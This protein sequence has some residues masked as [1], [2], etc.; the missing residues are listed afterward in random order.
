MQKPFQLKALSESRKLTQLF[1]TVMVALFSFLHQN[2]AYS[3]IENNIQSF[4]SNSNTKTN[5]GVTSESYIS[6]DPNSDVNRNQVVDLSFDGKWANEKA[7]T[8]VSARAALGVNKPSLYQIWSVPEVYRTYKLSN[9]NDFTFGRKLENWSVADQT[10]QLGI[11]QPRTRW[12]FLLPEQQGLTGLFYSHSEEEFGFEVFGSYL[13]IPDQSAKYE[14]NDGKFQSASQYF[15]F[16]ASSTALFGQTTP[17]KYGVDM[18]SYS[19]LLLQPEAAAKVRIGPKEG[20]HTQLGY[21]Y[22]PMNQVLMS[23]DGYLDLN[24][25]NAMVTVHPRVEYHH[26][27]TLE[28][29]YNNKDVSVWGSVTR[30]WPVAE[31]VASTYTSQQAAQTTIASIGSEFNAFKLF[32]HNTRM[33]ISYLKRVGGD[34]ED[35]GPFASQGNSL[36]ASRY[37]FKEAMMWNLHLPLPGKL[38]E[39]LVWNSKFLYEMTNQSSAIIGMLKYNFDRNWNAVVGGEILTAKAEI[40]S[41]GV[42]SDLISQN[43]ANDRVYGGV[44]YAF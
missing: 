14:I 30:E 12:N 6:P 21:A 24:S 33:G 32:T 19:K 22:K 39:R 4:H 35:K 31:S 2:L 38:G 28:G 41:S 18:P 37:P 5:L 10:W 8:G 11:W 29:I 44:S 43:R 17:V 3:F 25:Y 42:N 1:L 20:F 13:F 15:K 26:V 27:G 16:P 23:V 9:E 7:E 34:A 36:F 40:P